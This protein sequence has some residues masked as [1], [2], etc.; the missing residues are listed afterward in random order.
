IDRYFS[1]AAELLGCL[2]LIPVLAIFF[3]RE[4]DCI[5]EVVI[6]IFFRVDRRPRIRT[7]ASELHIMLAEYMRAQVLLCCLSF[8]FYSVV[9]FALRFP[10]AIALSLLGGLLEFVPVAGWLTAL[11]AIV[12][13]G[14]VSHSHW[15]WMA[16]LLGIW[17]VVQDYF[18]SP[19]IMGRHLK[20][21]PL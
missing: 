1:N 18:I 14:I 17:R 5:T 2:L 11:V 13:V 21:H 20:I 16:A 15:V 4:G 12:G 8:L 7:I 9:T 3:L 10:H 6:R 19:R